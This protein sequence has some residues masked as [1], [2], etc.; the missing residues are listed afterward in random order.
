MPALDPT[1]GYIACSRERVL[2][3][4]DT[5][6]QLRTWLDT[7]DGYTEHDDNPDRG[8]WNWRSYLDRKGLQI[9]A[10][11]DGG[12][13]IN[14]LREHYYLSRDPEEIYAVH[15]MRLS[16]L[17]HG[18]WTRASREAYFHATRATRDAT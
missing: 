15:D 12:Y 18:R 6:D 16:D 14:G 2:E 17:I 9:I 7:N 5:F 4:F 13:L 11:P 8:R 3:T 10:R 1:F